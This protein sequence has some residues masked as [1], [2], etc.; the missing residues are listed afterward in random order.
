MST[1]QRGI[2]E[3]PATELQFVAFRIACCTSNQFLGRSH[4]FRSS[5]PQPLGRCA[6]AAVRQ[7]ARPEHRTDRPEFPDA[8]P[9]D[10]TPAGRGRNP[11]V[12]RWPPGSLASSPAQRHLHDRTHH[13]DLPACSVGSPPPAKR[14][15]SPRL[16]ANPVAKKLY[17]YCQHS[18]N[19]NGAAT[20]RS[21]NACAAANCR[22]AEASFNGA[23]LLTGNVRKTE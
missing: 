18:S 11:N 5:Y 10:R 3:Q 23:A 2:K 6:N 7:R 14:E 20:L 22:T 17:G 12:R 9:T 21:R 13:T 16:H 1:T 15:R 19:S 8:G 4:D